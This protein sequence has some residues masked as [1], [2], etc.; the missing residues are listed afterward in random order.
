VGQNGSGKSSLVEAIAWALYGN[1]SSIVRTTKEGIR[2]SSAGQNDECSVELEFDL[3]A[4]HYRVV[5][6]IKGKNCTSDAT[7]SVNGSLS[8]RTDKCVTDLIVDRLGMDYKSFF[9]SVFARQKDL[10]ALSTLRPADRKKTILRM[11]EID[12]L[13]DVVTEIDKDA[14]VK[15]TELANLNLF[16]FEANGQEKRKRIEAERS[17]QFMR[18]TELIISAPTRIRAGAVTGWMN[19]PSAS[20]TAELTE[21]TRG[22][23]NRLRRKRIPT[24]TA[25]RPVRPPCATPVELSI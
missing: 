20:G 16:L 6:T 10:N 12:V 3:A 24:V 9:I 13:D 14:K 21:A 22:E 15:R 2:S 4:D 8:A 17:S 25:V 1:E 5:R 23:K 19:V 18:L 11:L 7:L